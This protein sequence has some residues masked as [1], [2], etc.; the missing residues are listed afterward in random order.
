MNLSIRGEGMG[1]ETA[2]NGGDDWRIEVQDEDLPE[3]A[4]LGLE[5]FDEVTGTGIRWYCYWTCVKR[6]GV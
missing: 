6:M 2:G 1:D 3:T 5:E 4:G